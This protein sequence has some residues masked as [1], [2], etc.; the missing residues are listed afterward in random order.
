MRKYLFG[1][2]SLSLIVFFLIIISNGNEMSGRQQI[3]KL[4]YPLIM[5]AGKLFGAKSGILENSGKHPGSSLYSISYTANNGQ[6]VSLGSMQGKKLLIVNTASDC[7]YTAQYETLQKLYDKY[8]DRLEI[9]AFPAND[10]KEQEKGSDE[11]IAHFCKVNYGISF[12]LARK[13]TVIKGNDQNPVFRWLSDAN[14]NGW[15][16]QAPEWNFSKYLVD[17]KG[18]LLRYFAP[19]VSPMDKSLTDILK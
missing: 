8:K 1:T 4:I 16:N 19:S 10:F 5:K 17:E 11:A 3:M 2:I 6:Q 7:G 12:P 18:V 13:T 14:L 9:I 15:C